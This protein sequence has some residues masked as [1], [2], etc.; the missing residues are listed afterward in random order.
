MFLKL[1]K[2]EDKK[3]NISR[4]LLEDPPPTHFTAAQL[5]PSPHCAAVNMKKTILQLNG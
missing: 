1:K 4:A 2:N 3:S 5:L